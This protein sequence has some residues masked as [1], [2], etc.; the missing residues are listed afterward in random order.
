MAERAVV[1]QHHPREEQSPQ[2]GD[3]MK[4]AQGKSPGKG[5][6]RLTALGGGESV[7]SPLSGIGA[8]LC[9]SDAADTP[10]LSFLS[11]RSAM[12]RQLAAAVPIDDLQSSSVSTGVSDA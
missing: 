4:L 11:P 2:V 9:S 10:A 8:F 1:V 7:R 5:E 3:R 6:R 12:R